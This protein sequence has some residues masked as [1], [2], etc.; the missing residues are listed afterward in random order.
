MVAAS[1]NRSSLSWLEFSC[2]SGHRSFGTPK[3]V[4]Q[5]QGQRIGVYARTCQ[6]FSVLSER[7]FVNR[8]RVRKRKKTRQHKS[9]RRAADPRPCAKRICEKASFANVY[10]LVMLL[11]HMF[12]F[13]LLSLV[14]VG[15]ANPFL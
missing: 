12:V 6:I 14:C 13:L 9:E 11:S 4:G 8:A 7:E 15:K 10:V 5:R 2:T 1:E 3:L